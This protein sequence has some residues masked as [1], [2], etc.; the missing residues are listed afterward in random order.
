MVLLEEDFRFDHFRMV[1]PD[2][3]VSLELTPRGEMPDTMIVEMV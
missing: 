3:A 1:L 2:N